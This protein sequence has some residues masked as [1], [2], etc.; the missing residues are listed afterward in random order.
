ML[1]LSI[2]A[3]HI[4]NRRYE[5]NGGGGVTVTVPGLINEGAVDTRGMRHVGGKTKDTLGDARGKKTSRIY[6]DLSSSC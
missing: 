4:H 3:A 5:W 1:S 6:L 2:F